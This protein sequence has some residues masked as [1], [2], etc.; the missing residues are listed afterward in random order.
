M[1]RITNDLHRLKTTGKM[2]GIFEKAVKISKEEKARHV[3]RRKR[4]HVNERP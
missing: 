4:N 1:N 3:H 2:R